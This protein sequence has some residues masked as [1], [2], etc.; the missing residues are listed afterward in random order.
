MTSMKYT[1]AITWLLPAVLL[2][3]VLKAAIVPQA[4]RESTAS[5]PAPEKLL[6]DD[7]STADSNSP[8]GAKWQ[9]I[10][11]RVMGGVSTGKL[12]MEK[13]AGRSAMHMTGNVS[14]ENNGG[15]IQARL[16]LD[17][18]AR[19][20]DA[21]AFKG[22]RLYVKGSGH[23]YAVHLRTAD[24]WLPWQFY[25]ADFK[26]NRSW[27]TIDLP[28]AAFKPASL[29]TPLNT[30]KLKT[31]AVVAI[32]KKF[33]AD[34]L[35]D[36][37]YLY[38]E[39]TMLRKLTP[40]EQ[41]VIIDK[42]TEPP[43]SGKYNDHF[44]KGAYTCR[45]CGA[46]IFDSSAKFKSDCGWP[47]F[48]DQIPGTV[49]SIPDPDGIRTEIVCAACGGHLGHVFKGEELTPKNT[50][51]C[52]NSI[53]MDFV[54]EPKTARAIFAGGCFWGVE[55][56]FKNAPGVLSTSVGYTGGTL[57]NP[58]YEQVCSDKTGHAE[59]IEVTFDPNKTSFEKLAKLF[60]EIHDFTQLNR[61]GPDV[62]SQ[63]R[64]A[65]FYLD[66]NQKKTAQSLVR[67][68]AEKG[69]DVKTR[70]VPATKFYPAE[71][72]HQDYYE[73]TGKTPYCHAYRKIF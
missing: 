36:N 38:R 48:D 62:G 26:T 70:I 40:A 6:I 15:F 31:V 71:L 45:Q 67:I 63:Y 52:V 49:K 2:A 21:S 39:P 3:I 65:L 10:T 56:H 20:F 17:P 50:R 5:A 23:T 9:L 58:T 53:S 30:K 24:T 37:L 29:K 42:G 54:P 33:T 11:D 55:H 18:K 47:S 43:F 1:N 28:F 44:E 59:A 35:I 22:I 41:R 57:E 46:E 27:Q 73:K 60:F 61:Q 68:L 72:Y 19:D 7:F 16:L 69:Y 12:A 14:L 13:H 64:S 25:Q 4:P 8:L 51:Y 34:I 32:K 66:E